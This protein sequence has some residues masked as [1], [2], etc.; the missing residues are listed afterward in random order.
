MH[1]DFLH[2]GGNLHPVGERRAV[3]GSRVGHEGHAAQGAAHVGYLG[4]CSSGCS[5]LFE[6]VFGFHGHVAVFAREH[7]ASC[8][9]RSRVYP[10]CFRQDVLS[11]VVVP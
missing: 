8:G 6:E 3:G 11:E 9:L 10:V 2:V 5:G 1:G 4:P 7:V